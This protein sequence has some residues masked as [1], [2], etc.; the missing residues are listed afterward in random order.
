MYLKDIINTENLNRVET[1]CSLLLKVATGA[2]DDNIADTLRSEN[3][4]EEVSPSPIQRST[5]DSLESDDTL[6]SEIDISVTRR[7][8]IRKTVSGQ[9]LL[10]GGSSGRNRLNS[11]VM[12]NRNSLSVSGNSANSSELASA[13]LDA[14]S[15]D[16]EDDYFSST[17]NNETKHPFSKAPILKQTS[18]KKL[19]QD[20]EEEDSDHNSDIED[21]AFRMSIQRAHST[22]PQKSV[23][24]AKSNDTTND[25]DDDFDEENYDNAMAIAKAIDLKN[26]ES[27]RTHTRKLSMSIRTKL[28][29][30]AGFVRNKKRD[31]KEPQ[32]DSTI[33]NPEEASHRPTLSG[34]Y[35]GDDIEQCRRTESRKDSTIK[36]SKS[37]SKSSDH[38]EKEG[39]EEE[40]VDIDILDD[41][42][43][44]D[45]LAQNSFH[46]DRIYKSFSDIVLPSEEVSI[47]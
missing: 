24:S 39:K 31:N 5:I 27:N 17:A 46:D 42:I 47:D 41:I 30:I 44:P 32:N 1:Y 2:F 4:T 18:I 28:N 19:W 23:F 45:M 37:F 6:A 40:E 34:I 12:M 3:E 26:E 16:I 43:D 8:A 11:I 21:S 13:A 33:N 20:I 22:L 10:A 38:L 7:N 9:M 35:G 36:I 14:L 25:D 15:V 29:S